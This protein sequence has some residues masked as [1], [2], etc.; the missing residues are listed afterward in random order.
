[1]FVIGRSLHYSQPTRK[2]NSN[3]E[4]L[5]GNLFGAVHLP[6]DRAF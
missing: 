5:F 4:I 3:F 6:Q 2:A 1:M